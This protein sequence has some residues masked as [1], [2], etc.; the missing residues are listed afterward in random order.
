MSG[1][2]RA[3]FYDSALLTYNVDTGALQGLNRLYWG[4]FLRLTGTF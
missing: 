2:I 4:P 1:G 3:D